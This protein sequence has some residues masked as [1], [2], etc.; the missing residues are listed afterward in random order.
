MG[1]ILNLCVLVFR[2]HDS[3]DYPWRPAISHSD[4]QKL[5]HNL[6][7]VKIRGTYSE[8]SKAQH[9]HSAARHTVTTILTRT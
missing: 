8:K 6:T 5:L 7:A 1:L 4:F 3:A 2:L 9:T